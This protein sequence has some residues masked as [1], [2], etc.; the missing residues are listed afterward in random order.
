[1]LSLDTLGKMDNG[2]ATKIIF[3]RDPQADRTVGWAPWRDRGRRYRDGKD[4]TS[5]TWSANRK[6]CWQDPNP[7]ELR[8]EVEHIESQLK[9]DLEDTAVTTKDIKKA[10]ME[11]VDIS[12]RNSPEIREFHPSFFRGLLFLG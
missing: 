2:Q 10:K 11:K 12:S 3:V 9:K 1:V 8:V 7:D 4:A 6:T 5:S